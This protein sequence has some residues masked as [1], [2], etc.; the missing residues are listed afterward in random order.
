M[1]AFVDGNPIPYMASPAVTAIPFFAFLPAVTK[2]SIKA[3]ALF[4]GF[5]DIT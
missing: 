2:V 5:P 3:T 4:L 1:G